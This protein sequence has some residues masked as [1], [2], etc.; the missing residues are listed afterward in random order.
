MAI[1]FIGGLWRRIDGNTIK[2]FTTYQDAVNNRT[3]WED[4]APQTTSDDIANQLN[5]PVD[6]KAKR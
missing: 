4:L 5:V 2:S 3:S 6:P 1:R